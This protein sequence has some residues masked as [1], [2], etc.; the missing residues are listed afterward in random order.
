M[1][2]VGGAM[3]DTE[4]GLEKLS[5][6]VTL[7]GTIIAG[8]VAMNSALTTCTNESAARYAG[9]RQAVA[10]E[11]AFWKELFADYL[12]VFGANVKP[13]EKTAKLFAISALAERNIPEF[14]EY[15]LG[16][17]DN[18]RAKQLAMKR[19]RTMQSRLKQ[20]L[21]RAES[22]DPALIAARQAERFASAEVANV[23]SQEGAGASAGVRAETAA[24]GSTEA[25]G[26][27]YETLVM[28][29]GRPEGWDIDLFWCA[30]GGLQTETLNFALA[31]DRGRMLAAIA[32][33]GDPLSPGVRLGRI[34]VRVLPEARQGLDQRTRIQYP[35]L[36]DGNQLRAEPGEGS[37]YIAVQRLLNREQPGFYYFASQTRTPWYFS[38]FACAP[39]SPVRPGT[40]QVTAAAT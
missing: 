36:G 4:A 40:A 35:K 13:E 33:K 8:F 17:L 16:L 1:L 39:P 38:L 11:E 32:D 3:G 23:S 6:R 25:T 28:S 10:A 37:A 30:G 7:L 31:R 9:F 5:K 18:P 27:T 26:L 12:S 24:A 29:A 34:R 20:A 14:T 19:L 2:E 22:S 21:D 15:R